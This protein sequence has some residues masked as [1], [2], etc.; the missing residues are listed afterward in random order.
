MAIPRLALLAILTA[1]GVAPALAA[2]PDNGER[3]A[4][5]WCATCHVVAEDQAGSTGEA[6]PFAEVAGA[7]DFDAAALALFLLDPHPVM[8]DMSLTRR[9]AS[10]LA[11]YIETLE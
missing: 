4:R 8:P 2:D 11:A 6:P 7:P 3:L 1:V 10:D 5:L 9:E